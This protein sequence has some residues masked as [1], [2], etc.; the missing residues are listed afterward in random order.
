MRGANRRIGAEPS[1]CVYHHS[2]SEERAA[3]DS[4]RGRTASARNRAI[5]DHGLIGGSIDDRLRQRDAI[6]RN[7]G[8]R[9]A[10]AR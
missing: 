9:A 10:L 6:D 5:P 1:R 3:G 7:R 2:L 8:Y 4:D